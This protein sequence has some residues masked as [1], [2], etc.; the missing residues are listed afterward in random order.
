MENL[1]QEEG[2]K[3]E[4]VF[5]NGLRSLRKVR[6]RNETDRFAGGAGLA[7]LVSFTKLV[8]KRG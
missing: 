2:L 7:T 6:I 4:G 5:L 1:T 8:A 3:F